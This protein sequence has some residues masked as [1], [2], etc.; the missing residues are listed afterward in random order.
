MKSRLALL[1]VLSLVCS[2]VASAGPISWL[3]RQVDDHPVRTRV[4]TTIVAGSIYAVGLHECRIHNVENCQAHYGA[5]WGSYAATMSADVVAQ[6]IG[7]KL[8]GW[9]GGAISY[10]SNIGVI[11]WGAYQW[12]GGLNKPS[13]RNHEHDDHK[14]DLSQVSIVHR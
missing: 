2:S 5:A 4:V 12:H 3:K 9:T 6:I 7:Y 8:G 14:V 13:D 10:G 1:L 11:A